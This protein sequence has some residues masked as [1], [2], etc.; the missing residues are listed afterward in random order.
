M[1]NNN[2]NNNSNRN[3][4]PNQDG[5]QRHKNNQMNHQ[6]TKENKEENKHVPLKYETRKVK[7]PPTVELKYTVNNRTV[8]ENMVVYKDRTPEEILKL[9]KEF[10]NLINTYNIWRIGGTVA[11]SAVITY[12]DFHCCLKGNARKIW[13]VIISNQPRNAA[14]FQVQVKKLIK[15]H[16]GQMLCRTKFY[17]W[18]WQGN[19]KAC[20]FCNGS[21]ESTT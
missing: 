7:D 2:N 8:K 15:K 4:N 9:V 21:T 19:Q 11:Q 5:R 17:T 10:Q 6:K 16:I 1:S 18:R 20:Q 3:Q 12:S 14:Q 13:D